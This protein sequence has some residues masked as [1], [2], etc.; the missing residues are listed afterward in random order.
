MTT[1]DGST[2]LAA[3]SPR[4]GFETSFVLPWNATFARV[5]ALD[6]DS[7]IIG[8][9]PAV[10]IRNGTLHELEYDIVSILESNRK[11]KWSSTPSST[12]DGSSNNKTAKD[13]ATVFYEKATDIELAPFYAAIV[14][15]IGLAL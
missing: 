5:A 11:Y 12:K 10:D 7:K 15:V 1:L 8:S 9:T 14:L 6:K 13:P 3:R 2:V 4:M